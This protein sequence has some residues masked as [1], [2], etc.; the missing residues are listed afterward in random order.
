MMTIT[1]T[2]TTTTITMIY[3][4]DNNY[5]GWRRWRWWLQPLV[6]SKLVQLFKNEDNDGWK[7]WQRWW[8]RRWRQQ[9]WLQPVALVISC[10]SWSKF[11]THLVRPQRRVRP[12]VNTNQTMAHLTPKFDRLCIVLFWDHLWIPTNAKAAVKINR[13]FLGKASSLAWPFIFW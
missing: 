4:N 1:M 12:F 3:D 13:I 11:W 2:M 7:L 5:E 8:Q 9:W 10:P 6:L